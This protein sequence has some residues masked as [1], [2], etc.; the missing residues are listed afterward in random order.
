M[1]RESTDLGE[2]LELGPRVEEWLSPARELATENDGL[3]ALALLSSRWEY[4]EAYSLAA[5][6]ALA[7][8]RSSAEV[9]E[10]LAMGRGH[11]VPRQL[12][13]MGAV[14]LVAAAAWVGWSQA[15]SFVEWCARQPLDRLISSPQVVFVAASDIN[16][17]IPATALAR[18]DVSW[19][20]LARCARH[21][22]E[23]GHTFQ[24]CVETE[25]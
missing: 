14:A 11:D 7:T 19:R 9:T 17:V 23:G 21:H 12:D 1:C 5:A 8:G 25:R 22:P 2:A 20:T 16:L 4:W 24:R 18:A 6:F 15:K 10:H 3:A 13:L